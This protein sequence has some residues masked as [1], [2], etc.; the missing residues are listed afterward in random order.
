MAGAA[1]AVIGQIPLIV[2]TGTVGLIASQVAQLSKAQR[3]RL[4]K[5]QPYY[6]RKCKRKHRYGTAVYREHVIYGR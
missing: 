4:I 6:C 1:D 5:K 2:A 3:K